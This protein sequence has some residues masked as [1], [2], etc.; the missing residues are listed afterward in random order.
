MCI[1]R[2]R[3]WIAVPWLYNRADRWGVF[4][5]QPGEGMID[6]T[7]SKL[8]LSFS[9]QKQLDL[10]V[11]VAPA[12]ARSAAA[13]VYASYAAATGLPSPLPSNVP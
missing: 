8:S 6:A 7:G 2:S 9:C 10:W 1:G 11:S 4:L 5:N 3:Y 12:A 13:A